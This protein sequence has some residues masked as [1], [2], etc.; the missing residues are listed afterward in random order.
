MLH[1]ERLKKANQHLRVVVAARL[2]QFEQVQ[3]QAKEYRDI[4]QKLISLFHSHNFRASPPSPTEQT[5]VA[6]SVFNSSC[7]TKLKT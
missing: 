2:K 7:D 1:E 4:G 6:N 3:A 5:K